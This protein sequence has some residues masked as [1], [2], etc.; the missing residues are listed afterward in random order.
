MRSSAAQQLGDL[1]TCALTSNKKTTPKTAV[2]NLGNRNLRF[3][4]ESLH[5]FNWQRAFKECDE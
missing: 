3:L 2:A 5:L 1:G 4:L